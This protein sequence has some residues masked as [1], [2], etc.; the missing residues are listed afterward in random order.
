MSV[1]TITS[2][3]LDPTA[4]TPSAGAATSSTK[5]PT[6][7]A[8]DSLGKNAFLQLLVTQL[9]NQD[10]L[11]PQDNSAFLAQLAQF[12]SL[13]QLQQ[14]NQNT[15]QLL[16]DVSGSQGTTLPSAGVTPTTTTSA[17]SGGN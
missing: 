2:T 1:S 15:T 12:S 9:K 14:I 16:G 10:P 8:N 17:I 11:Q 5:P 3:A 4:T 13:E 7:T 6:S